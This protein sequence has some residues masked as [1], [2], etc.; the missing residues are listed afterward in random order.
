MPGFVTPLGVTEMTNILAI[1]LRQ[2]FKH[3][4]VLPVYDNNIHV[5]IL[6]TCCMVEA[7]W[8]VCDEAEL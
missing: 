3:L 6:Q 8:I 4:L 7:K 1:K 5:M 2:T